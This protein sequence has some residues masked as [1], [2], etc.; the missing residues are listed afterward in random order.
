[1][2][3]EHAILDYLLYLKEEGY[4]MASAHQDLLCKVYEIIIRTTDRKINYGSGQCEKCD[5]V[6]NTVYQ[7]TCLKREVN[8]IVCTEL[9]CSQCLKID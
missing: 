7:R 8:N 6:Y 3:L 9:I 4:D 1:M 2:N 5:I